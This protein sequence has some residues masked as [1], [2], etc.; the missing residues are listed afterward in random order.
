MT[1]HILVIV[2]GEGWSAT[3]RICVYICSASFNL[4]FFFSAPLLFS[5]PSPFLLQSCRRRRRRRR[6]RLRRRRITDRL[7]LT[8]RETN[9][10][11]FLHL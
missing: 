9:Y 10:Y 2:G 8:C 5:S 7:T 3:M 4:Y 1:S 6:R 11:S